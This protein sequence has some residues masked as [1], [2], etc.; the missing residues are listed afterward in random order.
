MVD[1]RIETLGSELLAG[2]EALFD[3]L[4]KGPFEVVFLADPGQIPNQKGRLEAQE[5]MQLT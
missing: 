4:Q 1:Q 5:A 2:S 3:T